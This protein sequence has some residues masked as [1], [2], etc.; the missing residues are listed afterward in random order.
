MMAGEV[1]MLFLGALWL[2]WL[3][4][5]E[6]AFALGVGPFVL[7]DLVKVALATCLVYAGANAV[8]VY[9]QKRER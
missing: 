5:A 2:G 9:R 3:F 7:T 8:R 6:K 1:V 4:G